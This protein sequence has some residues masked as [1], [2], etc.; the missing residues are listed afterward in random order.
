MPRRRIFLSRSP[1]LSP[2]QGLSPFFKIRGGA[3]EPRLTSG[4]EADADG[5]LHRSGHLKDKGL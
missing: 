1:G 5:L 2:N 3:A 4:G